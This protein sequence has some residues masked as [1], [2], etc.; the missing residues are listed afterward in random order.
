MGQLANQDHFGHIADIW[1]EGNWDFSGLPNSTIQII[2]DITI[3]TNPQSTDGH[4]SDIY[5]SASAY[6]V[7]MPKIQNYPNPIWH[8][9]WHISKF[10]FFFWQIL[11]LALPTNAKGFSV[12]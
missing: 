8:R 6:F 11:Y 4:A 5:S 2:A 10:R 12:T 7:L 9:L 1:K 3:T